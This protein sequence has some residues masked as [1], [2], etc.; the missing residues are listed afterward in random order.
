[1][2]ILFF[3]ADSPL[4]EERRDLL[5]EAVR[6]LS[7]PQGAV[8]QTFDSSRIFRERHLI[9]ALYHAVRSKESGLSRSRDLSVDVVRY[10][11]GE[12][13]IHLAFD[14]V[15]LR[16][17]TRGIAVLVYSPEKEIEGIPETLTRILKENGFREAEEPA[18]KTEKELEALERAALLDLKL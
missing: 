7:R 9:S 14:K 6:G 8:I 2:K 11:A 17:G 16:K 13:Q 5:I 12:R 1:M 4:T 18:V 3:K 15:G 10:A